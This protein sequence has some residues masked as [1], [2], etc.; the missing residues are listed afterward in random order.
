MGRLVLVGT[1]IGNLDDASPRSIEALRDADVIA[2]EDTRRTRKLLSHF[3]VRTRELVVYRD[4]N[5]RRRIPELLERIVRGETVALVSDAGMP[6]LSDPGYRLVRA[7]AEQGLEV[8]VVPGPSAAISA[9]AVS[10]LPP[11][12][13]TFEGFLPRK[14][15]DRK[16]RLLDLLDEPRTM[17]F[18][19]S[20][21]RLG[22]A[23]A[24]MA[25]VLGERPATVVRE[26]TK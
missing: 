14:S 22:D 10:G 17:V 16:R 18:F 8:T 19:E 24:D 3:G 5:E 4:D 15:G 13:F 20:P 11:A 9:V 25:E 23:L 21:H 12:R 26:L 1:P 2:C 7:C 6:G